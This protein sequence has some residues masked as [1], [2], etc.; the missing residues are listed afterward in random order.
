[1]E[2]RKDGGAPQRSVAIEVLRWPER[3]KLRLLVQ[4]YERELDTVLSKFGM[5]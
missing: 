3:N 2:R 4:R 5:G 1:M